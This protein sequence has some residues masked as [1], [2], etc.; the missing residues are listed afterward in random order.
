MAAAGQGR[1]ILTIPAG[2][3][4][5]QSTKQKHK[6]NIVVD[7]GDPGQISQS[8]FLPVFIYKMEIVMIPTS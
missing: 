2:H 6:R 1:S 4:R 7:G 3:F 8:L 5:N